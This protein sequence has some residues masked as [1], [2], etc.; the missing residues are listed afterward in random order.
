M[1]G[2]SDGPQEGSTRYQFLPD[3]QLLR[4]NQQM[5]NLERDKMSATASTMQPSQPSPASTVGQQP[6]L[7][8]TVPRPEPTQAARAQ[9]IGSLSVRID[10]LKILNMLLDEAI[11]KA[12]RLHHYL[13]AVR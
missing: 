8:T 7:V 10:E 11:G 2:S 5:A 9:P 6:A 3:E 1:S 4:F 12:E 13:T